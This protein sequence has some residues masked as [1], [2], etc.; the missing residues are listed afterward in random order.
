MKKNRYKEAWVSLYKC[1]NVEEEEGWEMQEL[2][3]RILKEVSQ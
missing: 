3:D 2:M 1:F